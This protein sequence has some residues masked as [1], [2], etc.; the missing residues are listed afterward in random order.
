MPVVVFTGSLD[1][2]TPISQCDVDKALKT[3]SAWH[4]YEG[5]THG[6]DAPFGGI[7][8]RN[9]TDGACT[10]ADNIYN[11]FP[12]CRSNKYTDHMRQEIVKFVQPHN[13]VTARAKPPASTQSSQPTPTDLT[14]EE[15]TEEILRELAGGKK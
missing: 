9:P 13:A 4:H 1:Q 12:V 8:S 5:A 3:A 14:V 7:G 10:K 11:H 2:A 6:W 15:R